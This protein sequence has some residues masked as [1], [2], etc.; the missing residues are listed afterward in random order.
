MTEDE[1]GSK[2]GQLYDRAVLPKSTPRDLWMAGL[3]GLLTFGVTW[4]IVSDF[5]APF[6]D[7]AM[8]LR[9][10]E[11]LAAGHGITWNV[12]EAPVDGATDFLYMVAVA[13]LHWLG[14]PVVLAGKLLS[15]ACHCLTVPIIYLANRRTLRVGVAL[16]TIAALAFG[17]GPGVALIAAHFG[18]PMFALGAALVWAT[19]LHI[20]ATGVTTG[21]AALFSFFGLAMSLVRPEGVFLTLL[22]L[23]A[24]VRELEMPSIRRIL[25][26]FALV[27]G[28]LGGIYFV[29]RWTY[30]GYPL[31]NPFYK[32]GGGHLYPASLVHAVE[33]V[34]R[35]SGVFLA[36]PVLAL[37][38]PRLVRTAVFSLIPVLGFSGI[39]LFL[40]DEMNFA[41][42]FQYAIMPIALM[43]FAPFA[44]EFLRA[45]GLGLGAWGAGWNRR[46]S[47]VVVVVLGLFGAFEL[48][49]AFPPEYP[50]YAG[51]REVGRIL[52]PYKDRGYTIAVTEAGLL[53]LYS[54][55]KAVDIWGLN[56]AEISHAGEVSDEYL[57]RRR[58]EVILFH[59]FSS[60]V[61]ESTRQEQLRGWTHMIET[62]RAYIAKNDYE[63]VA[64]FGHST[65]D[66]H[67]YF[68]R[69]DFPE[70]AP[71]AAAI[72]KVP[73]D[74]YGPSVN[75]VEVL[76][77]T[78]VQ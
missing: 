6:E 74:W 24:L 4:M 50:S 66:T 65:G 23:F 19:A 40:S 52:A 25:G 46:A 43:S 33:N 58:P 75:W 38:N 73:Y 16:S 14:T 64:A 18:T 1:N 59:A 76:E 49:R 68:V 53:P 63:L 15:L 77:G 27:F 69:R 55:W 78:R 36:F 48:R 72:R 62:T 2:D 26:V 21:S 47:L 7:A 60:P 3:L 9:Y 5:D 71:I 37:F 41:G 28:G 11:H 17:L 31:P 10:S 35:S 57:A 8:L 45:A 13:F 67:W 44:E 56:D 39:W 61:V 12:G 54:K 51:L 70:Y 34:L 22:V 30:F 20:R 42:R 32:K 29:W